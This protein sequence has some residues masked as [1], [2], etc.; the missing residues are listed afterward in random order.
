MNQNTF[1]AL[2]SGKTRGLMPTVIRILLWPLAKAY[3]LAILGR[4]LLF[5]YSILPSYTPPC[6]VICIGNLTT[7]GTGKTPLVAW[8]CHHLSE[9]RSLSVTV[10]TRGY[11]SADTQ[12][13]EPAMLE[14]QLGNVP[15]IVNADR[16][17]GTKTALARGPVDVFVM[18]DGF[19]HLRLARDLNILTL[20]ATNPF[21]FEKL[22][23]AGLLREP[24]TAIKRA[25]CIVITRSDQI[26]RGKLDTLRRRVECMCPG[27]ALA[28]TVHAPA[29]VH[30]AG[31][32]SESFDWLKGR[33][34]FAFCGIGNPQAFFTTVEQ[35]GARL[36][37]THVFDDH[38]H[39][40]SSEFHDL[41]EQ[42]LQNGA[43]ILLTTEKN[44]PDIASMNTQSDLPV[45]Y[46]AVKMT[47]ESGED[48]V[49]EL[50]EQALASRISPS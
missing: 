3:G 17:E 1:H 8:L 43:Y 13:D 39:C 26:P 7:G 41:H 16:I 44:F 14:K 28:T 38:H 12:T 11:K 25:Q 36:V 9:E 46:L 30:F 49:K 37:G 34:V 2:V 47:F 23:P 15:V 33:S 24:I 29:Q 10:L 32:P 40:T 21:G 6:P 5:R 27:M 18:D 4:T 35:I 19:Q 42:A 48:R 22:L 31:A 45:G 20:D 50:I